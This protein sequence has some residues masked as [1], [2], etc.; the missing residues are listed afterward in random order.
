MCVCRAASLLCKRQMK[1]SANANA[2]HLELARERER[3]RDTK[4][5]ALLNMCVNLQRVRCRRPRHPIYV[6]AYL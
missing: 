4:G 2:T 3:N 1:L 5:M 6:V